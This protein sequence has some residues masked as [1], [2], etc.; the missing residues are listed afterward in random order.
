MALNRFWMEKERLS[1]LYF[2]TIRWR[3]ALRGAEAARKIT[4]TLREL[5]VQYRTREV[6]A[7]CE[8]S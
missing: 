3:P 7:W 4:I 5:L 6:R 2:S 8:T 1:R